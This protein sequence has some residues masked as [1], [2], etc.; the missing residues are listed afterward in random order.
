MLKGVD[1]LIVL[2][3]GLGTI[4]EL[5][6]VLAEKDAHGLSFRCDLINIDGYFDGFLTALR[7]VMEVYRPHVEVG[8]F[9]NIVQ[10]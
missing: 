6:H 3:G 5:M 2:L 9:L 4:D 10:V 1:K 8:S 7:Q